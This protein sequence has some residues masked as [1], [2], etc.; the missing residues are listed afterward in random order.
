[1]VVLFTCDDEIVVRYCSNVRRRE[2]WDESASTTYI[3]I[4]III[5][6]LLAYEIPKNGGKNWNLLFVA[7]SMYLYKPSF[8][9]T[10]MDHN[11]SNDLIDSQLNAK[12]V[13]DDDDDDN[14][15]DHDD[16]DDD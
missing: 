8:E 11:A 9:E 7:F 3:I 14:D 1:M 16:D 5:I 12:V 13:D 6:R 10:T 15:D 4:I 2:P